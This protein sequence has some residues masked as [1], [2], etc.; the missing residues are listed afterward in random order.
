L[1]TTA[2][3]AKATQPA[4][5]QRVQA[6]SILGALQRA[7][8]F[9]CTS[10][11]RRPPHKVRLRIGDLNFEVLKKPMMFYK[12]HYLGKF[13][14]NIIHSLVTPP[15]FGGVT[16]EYLCPFAQH[17][18][19]EEA[20][21]RGLGGGL[22][23]FAWKAVVYNPTL[24]A[25]V[26]VGASRPVGWRGYNG[27]PLSFA[28]HPKNEEAA[29][30]GLGGGLTIFAWKAVVYNPTLAA[31]MPAGA[32]PPPCDTAVGWRGYN[33]IPLSFAQH[34]KYEEAADHGSGGGEVHRGRKSLNTI[35]TILRE[36]AR[37]GSRADWSFCAKNNW[38]DYLQMIVFGI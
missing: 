23:I 7:I 36:C 31:S 8:I 3:H 9:R 10:V 5:K 15:W 29:D 24:T 20:A 30:R 1:N 25:S 28:Q 11:K 4:P 18:K 26:P 27:T 32:S 2:F 16:T 12:E 33:G 19:H 13:A 14:V 37:P 35:Q 17:P 38:I 6:S 34:P 22:T 21:D